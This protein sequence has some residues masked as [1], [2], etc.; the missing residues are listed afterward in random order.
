MSVSR[1]G[2]DPRAWLL[3]LDDPATASWGGR[4][5]LEFVERGYA[6]ALRVLRA[7]R[8]DLAREKYSRDAAAMIERAPARFR[9]EILTHPLFG[10]WIY[11]VHALREEGRPA[12]S[13]AW[14]LAFSF[15]RGF[16]AALAVKARKNLETVV[17]CDGRGL[18]HLHGLGAYYDFGAGRAGAPV[19]LS[20]KGGKARGAGALVRLPRVGGTVEVNA[21]DPLVREVIREHGLL[22]LS[23]DKKFLKRLDQAFA[24]MRRVDPRLAREI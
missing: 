16:A 18:A 12:D 15:L 22:D 13:P 19:A 4:K 7:K 1:A 3:P 24:L 5:R 21:V 14:I 11:L 20:I 2:R 8:P 6:Q 17:V 10:F 23:R 9:K